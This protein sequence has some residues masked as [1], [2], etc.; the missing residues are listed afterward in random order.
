VKTPPT[1]QL[2]AFTLSGA[3]DRARWRVP[4]C[5]GRFP[6]AERSSAANRR[7]M[8]LRRP[9]PP[10]WQRV[11]APGFHCVFPRNRRRQPHWVRARSSDAMRSSGSPGTRGA[12]QPT[13]WDILYR[14]CP[15]PLLRRNRPPG[16]KGPDLRRTWGQKNASGIRCALPNGGSSTTIGRRRNPAPGERY[17]DGS[18]RIDLPR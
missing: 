13:Q 11:P 4:L 12:P 14:R 2:R 18:C 8:R 10:R 7:S 6:L 16:S 3:R 15:D 1:W 5:G 9:R 17:R